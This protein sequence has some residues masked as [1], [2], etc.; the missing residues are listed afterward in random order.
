V[1]RRLLGIGMVMAAVSAMV[2]AMADASAYQQVLG[3]YESQGT[4]PACR[5]SGPELA[6]ALK[7]VDTYGAQYF[8]DF[9]QAVQ[10]ALS[11]RA[12]GA[13]TGAVPPAPVQVRGGVAEPPAHFG[14]VTAATSAGVPAPLAVLGGLA[15]VG[16]LF[17]AGTAVVRSR[18]HH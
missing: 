5:F 11:S 8:A 12:A 14:S 17:G 18:A 1:L 2:P 7:G 9:T 16:A 4:V 10:A 13:C 15:L 3:V 6:D